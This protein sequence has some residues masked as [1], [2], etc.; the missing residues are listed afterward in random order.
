M[1]Q[2]LQT[3][4]AAAARSPAGRFIGGAAAEAARHCGDRARTALAKLSRG[5]DEDRWR[6]A[7]AITRGERWLTLTW[8]E[9]ALVEE[10]KKHDSV[11]NGD[12][13]AYAAAR[14][15]AKAPQPWQLSDSCALCDEKFHAALRRHHCRL[16]G[17]SICRHHGSK[18]RPLPALAAHLGGDPLRVCDACDAELDELE[19]R[20]RAEWRT[21]RA[22]RFLGDE[23][24]VAYFDLP[25]GLS[26]TSKAR[27]CLTAAQTLARSCPLVAPATLYVA[28][29]VLE[30]LC[31]YGPAGLA[32][33]V[34][35]REFVEAAELLRKVAGVDEGWPRSAHELTAAIFYLLALNRGERGNDP[36]SVLRDF[37]DEPSVEDSELKK[38]VAAARCALWCYEASPTCVQ[39]VA[40]QQGLTLLFARGFPEGPDAREP[41]VDE[42]AF[43]C[44]ASTIQKEVVLAV[45][46]T[47]T[48]QDVATDVRAAP[49]PFPPSSDDEWVL[50][51]DAFAFAG[52]ARAAEYVYR[53]SYDALKKLHD[54]G[55]SIVLTGHSLGAGVASLTAVL[56][57]RSLERVHCVAFAAPACV[58]GRLAEAMRPFVTSVV[59][60]DDVVPR[61]TAR[62][63]RRLV[64]K[65]LH[66][67]QSCM[68]H[69]RADLDAAWG[70]L[71]DGLWAPRVRDSLVRAAGAPP[72][73]TQAPEPPVVAPPAPEPVVAPPP[74]PEPPAADSDDDVD[75]DDDS[76][77]DDENDDDNDAAARAEAERQERRVRR[78]AL[79]AARLA[80]VAVAAGEAAASEASTDSDDDAASTSSASFYDCLNGADAADGDADATASSSGNDEDDDEDGWG[81]ESSILLSSASEAEEPPPKVVVVVSEPR[82][83]APPPPPPQQQSSPEESYDLT[84][85]MDLP[86]LFVPGAVVH[87]YRW[88]GTHRAARIDR[89]HTVLSDV[90]VSA[91]MLSDHGMRP[92][93][94][95]LGE[96]RAVNASTEDPPPWQPFGASETCA[97]CHSRFTWHCTSRSETTAYREKHHC[98]ACGAL[99]CDPC[100]RHRLALPQIGLLSPRRVCDR[101]F[102]AGGVSSSS[103]NGGVCF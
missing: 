28:V 80:G 78:A 51:G 26:A 5:D 10:D 70:R 90:V 60:G 69:W 43:F 50:D 20:E 39:L 31:R 41:V 102:Y 95:A 65:L 87:L 85:S 18:K 17:R 67:R 96:V 19:R 37:R 62:A 52:M 11:L 68:T 56:L 61:L 64:Q 91:A 74:A 9:K 13:A 44:A 36:D 54:A 16:C 93:F 40:K 101:C 30:I 12:E 99:V 77:S 92:Y 55:Y 32:T 82:E 59:L 63:L 86:E 73:L 83:P 25:K 47:S 1:A 72:A 6:H 29:E 75:S 97:C 58:D 14:L 98:R 38:L 4:A 2:R 3:T 100:S 8:Y 27:R 76:E 35:R 46:G 48:V 81:G 88:R 71:R 94:E 22:Q 24:V 42:P 66:E 57:K 15:A 103:Q 33:L 49:A 7:D 34:L 79:S 89:K 53:E 21:Y 23:R 45:R 84:D